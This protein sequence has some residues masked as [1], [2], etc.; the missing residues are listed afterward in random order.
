[1]SSLVIAAEASAVPSGAEVG[2]VASAAI[3]HRLPTGRCR[4]L[5]Q[6]WRWS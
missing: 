1:M 3:A 6:S 4:G 2:P 5:E